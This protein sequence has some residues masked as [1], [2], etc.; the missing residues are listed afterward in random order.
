MIKLFLVGLAW[1]THSL[2]YALSA[3]EVLKNHH[4]SAIVSTTF[5]L[6]LGGAVAAAVLMTTSWQRKT[7]IIA[8]L[9][10]NDLL[11]A[12]VMP[13]LTYALTVWT[14]NAALQ[15]TSIGLT[16]IVKA[17]EPLFAV[18]LMIL[19]IGNYPT[20]KELLAVVTAVLG[21]II[22]VA[23]NL[24]VEWMAV[25]FAFGS[26]LFQQLRNILGKRSMMTPCLL[27]SEF[28]QGEVSLLL[29]ALWSLF[30]AAGM[31]LSAPI[32][33]IIHPE[34]LFISEAS[35]ELTA[36]S[37]RMQ[38]WTA[39]HFATYQVC[40]ILVLSAVSP[41]MHALANSL[42]R[43]IIIFGSA[44]ILGLVITAQQGIGI[45]ITLAG[46]Y[47]YALWKQAP[48]KASSSKSADK[49]DLGPWWLVTTVVALSLFSAAVIQPHRP[50]HPVI[51]AAHRAQGHAHLERSLQLDAEDHT[52]S[53]GWNQ[54]PANLFLAWMNGERARGD[55][56]ERLRP[57]LSQAET[58]QL[59]CVDSQCD[60]QFAQLTRL[61][62]P[63]N[64]IL[65]NDTDASSVV[66]AILTGLIE[67]G[68][69]FL[70][71]SAD[72]QAWHT[73]RMQDT[74]AFMTP[75]QHKIEA[76][77]RGKDADLPMMAVPAND[78]HA[79][80]SLAQFR[81]HY[82]SHWTTALLVRWLHSYM[83]GGKE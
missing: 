50:P 83:N 76:T 46:V 15:G 65:V 56:L 81:K 61:D 9:R 57:L 37:H 32:L 19:L 3:S 33:L 74:A 16:F 79:K 47:A 51:D 59:I 13:A 29:V 58:I 66:T 26:N 68:G 49:T 63:I 48:P 10:N 67:H 39:I 72:M 35:A 1:Y 42:K 6:V 71:W 8:C 43:G 17:I 69:T 5:Q 55:T 70:P 75:E 11:K 27:E 31:V 77:W 28:T 25:F 73:A 30:G 22:T 53:F 23:S 78:K 41:V 36:H 7:Q 20:S 18:V 62:K 44:I 4:A 40:S 12:T 60:E 34:P 82:R 64:V 24:E 2:Q 21:C 38:F 45:V 54:A 52:S 14:T 80:V